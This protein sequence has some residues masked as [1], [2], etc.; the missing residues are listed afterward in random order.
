MLGKVTTAVPL[1]EP[2]VETAVLL[3]LLL[4]AAGIS[5][6]FDKTDGYDLTIAGVVE[7][8]DIDDGVGAGD[9]ERSGDG[10]GDAVAVVE[11]LEVA[12]A[13]ELDGGGGFA[14]GELGSGF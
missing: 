7:V 10:M 8:G 5:A 13:G 9:E 6:G 1:P 3:K 4:R 14:A 11:G 12:E 2:S